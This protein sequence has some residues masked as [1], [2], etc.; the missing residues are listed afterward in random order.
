MFRIK[1][2]R[3]IHCWDQRL[4]NSTSQY[5]GFIFY[6]RSKCVVTDTNKLL[7]HFSKVYLNNN[8]FPILNKKVEKED[9]YNT[10]KDEFK[11]K[12]SNVIETSLVYNIPNVRIYI[13]YLKPNSIEEYNNYSWKTYWDFYNYNGKEDLYE[14]ILDEVKNK[15]IKY[16]IYPDYDIHLSFKLEKIYKF[17]IGF[18]S[19]K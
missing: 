12:S 8:K 1:R 10:L 17:M 7:I 2:K 3:L 19:I 18:I 5:T 15:H 4:I 9:L 11:I 6:S 16:K 14:N 13:V